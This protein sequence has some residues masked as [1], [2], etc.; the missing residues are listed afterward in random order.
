MQLSINDLT[1]LSLN[2]TTYRAELDGNGNFIYIGYA[3][4]GTL[5]SESKWQIQK[6]LFDSTFNVPLSITFPNGISNQDFIWDNRSS[7]QYK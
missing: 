6:F 4:P 7:Y 1:Y 5:T 2:G 3:N